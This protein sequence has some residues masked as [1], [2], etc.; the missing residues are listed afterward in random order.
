MPKMRNRLV[1][2]SLSV[3]FLRR[4]YENDRQREYSTDRMYYSIDP[5]CEFSRTRALFTGWITNVPQW[6]G[7]IGTPLDTEDFVKMLL[8]SDV[9]LFGG[10]GSGGKLLE[11]E[12]WK[13][14]LCRAAVLLFG[15]GSVGNCNP[16]QYFEVDFS[17]LTRAMFLGG[18]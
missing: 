13:D 3:H 12:K 2:R 14:L 5:G 15:C 17:T 10:H 8:E 18:W 11:R 9:Y 7:K 6:H 4:D 1:C 16:V